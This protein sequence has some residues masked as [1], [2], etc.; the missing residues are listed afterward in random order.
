M[1]K[2]QDMKDFDNFMDFIRD[3]PDVKD[4]ILNALNKAKDTNNPYIFDPMT[5]GNTE[6]PTIKQRLAMTQLMLKTNKESK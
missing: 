5:D 6:R 3:N 1:S 4:M 2:K